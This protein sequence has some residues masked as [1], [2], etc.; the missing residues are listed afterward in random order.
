VAM[1]S[2]RDDVAQLPEFHTDSRSKLAELCLG[3]L[4]PA[5]GSLA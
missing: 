2:D 4:I 3:Q 5:G 1:V